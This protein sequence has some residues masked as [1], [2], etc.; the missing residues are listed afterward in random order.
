[1]KKFEGMKLLFLG[2][3]VGTLDMIRYAK[4]NGAYTI[5]ADYLPQEKS[6]GK[7]YA[8]RQVLLSTGD[9]EGLKDYIMKEGVDGVLAGVLMQRQPTLIRQQLTHGH[10]HSPKSKRNTLPQ[11][12]SD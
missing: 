2:S 10:Q 7:Q 6:V 1:M 11:R 4:E 12:Y 9:L 5:V 8:D 3:N